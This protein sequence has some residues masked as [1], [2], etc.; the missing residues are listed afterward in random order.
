M[1]TR[2][3]AKLCIK[4]SDFIGGGIDKFGCVKKVA[5]K[6]VVTRLTKFRELHNDE[7]MFINGFKNV[8]LLWNLSSSNFD[9]LRQFFKE[10]KYF[11]LDTKSYFSLP[12]KEKHAFLL[13]SLHKW[14]T[15]H[16][17]GTSS[18]FTGLYDFMN[19]IR[20]NF[21]FLDDNS[22]FHCLTGKILEYTSDDIR[23]YCIRIM[24]RLNY[25]HHILYDKH[26]KKYYKIINE[27]FN[28]PIITQINSEFEQ[29][30]TLCEEWLY[31]TLNTSMEFDTFFKNEA[32]K[33][34]FVA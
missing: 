16:F 21:K 7:L 17:I 2:I 30:D 24:V 12:G 23:G 32:P 34:I 8:L 6:R 28:S 26:V 14:G 27:L 15:H 33:N 29:L 18:I 22:I 5:Y 10:K 9:Q 4:R 25:G 19:N 31:H 1:C 13:F 20:S 11:Q 3:P